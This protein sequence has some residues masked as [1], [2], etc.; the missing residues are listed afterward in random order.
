MTGQKTH[1]YLPPNVRIPV[2]LAAV[3]VGP[4]VAVLAA[5]SGSE[6]LWAFASSVV[7]MVALDQ[8]YAWMDRRE[9]RG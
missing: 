4:A 1:G 8:L 6:I 7:S 5:G 3:A 9:H 2:L